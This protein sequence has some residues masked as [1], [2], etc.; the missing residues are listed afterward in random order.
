MEK[1]IYREVKVEVPVEVIK[2]VPKIIEKE[3]VKLI[4]V[5]KEVPVETIRTSPNPDP[6]PKPN[7]NPNPA[8]GAHRDDPHRREDRAAD[9]REGRHQGGRGAQVGQ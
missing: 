2:E 3:V 5:I 4:E 9:R 1:I 8:P 6:D 7:P